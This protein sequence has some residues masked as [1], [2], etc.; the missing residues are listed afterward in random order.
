MENCTGELYRLYSIAQ[1]ACTS[2]MYIVYVY[3]YLYKTMCFV[4]GVI[5][6]RY[7]T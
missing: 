1:D 2:Y 7:C 3:M 5:V 4:C 6:Y